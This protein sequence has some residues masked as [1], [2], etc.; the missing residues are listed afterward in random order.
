MD[1]RSRAA[2]TTALLLTVSV[3]GLA[4]TS[5]AAQASHPHHAG[6]GAGKSLTITIKSKAGSVKLSDDKIRPGNTTFQVKNMDAKDS[7]GLV[8]IFRL[9]AGYT[10][11]TAFADFGQLFT[12]P[13]TADSIAAVDRIDKNVVFYGGMEAKGKPSKV[14]TWAVKID[15]TGTYYVA[16]LDQNTLTTLTVKGSRQKRA[17]PHQDGFIDPA[18]ANND[19]GNTFKAGKHNPAS[20][21]M[22]TTNKAKEPHFVDVEQVKKGTKNSDITALFHGTGP[23]VFVK[24]GG[25]ADT[26]VISPGHRFLW[27][28]HVPTGKYAVLCFWPGKNDGMPHAVMGMHII[29]HLG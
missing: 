16:N 12:D 14:S 5:G 25:S 28:Y 9:K 26:G 8:Q 21:W 15:K 2:A 24:H 29:T 1:T 7:K 17:L 11:D 4:A 22:S 27:A 13:P 6:S 20:G 23:N 19:A 18:S 10:L 3:G